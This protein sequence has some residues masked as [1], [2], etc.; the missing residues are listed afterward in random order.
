M[1]RIS[2]NSNN[3]LDA[4]LFIAPPP[5][6]MTGFSASKIAS[7]ALSICSKSGST[8]GLYD[9]IFTSFG[10][11]YSYKLSGAVVSLGISITTGPGLPDV[12]IWNA[13]LT[14]RGISD[15]SSTV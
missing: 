12:A 8:G 4:L 6:Y 5:A 2:F 15:A 3:S 13:S 11:S 1:F 7:T 10:Y 14:M 9:L